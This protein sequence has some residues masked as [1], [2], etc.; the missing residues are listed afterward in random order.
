M[1]L[2]KKQFTTEFAG[3]TLTMEVSKL[4]EQATS[5]V[6]GRYGDA[7]V[8]VTVVMSEQAK[9]GDYFPLMVNYEERFY[10]AGKILGS[11]FMRREGRPSENAVLAGR[12]IDRTIR[13]LFDQ[14]TRN[15]VQVVVTILQID[16]ETDLD[17]LT[18]ATTSVALGIS[19]IPWNGPVAGV[20]L[21]HDGSKVA[22]NPALSETA[23]AWPV[24]GGF[25]AFVAGT[26]DRMNMIELEGV[27]ALDTEVTK[28]FD[29][30]QKDIAKLVDWQKGI[31]KEIGVEKVAMHLAEAD[32]ATTAK[33][34]A[35]LKEHK[36]DEVAYTRDKQERQNRLAE[37]KTALIEHLTAE[38]VD[39][40]SLVHLD[41]IIDEEIDRIMHRRILE[42]DERP[43]GR[44][45]DEVR[46]LYGETGLFSRTH[47][48]ALFVRG[49]TQALAITTLAPP[50]AERLMETMSNT[51]KRSFMLHYNFPPYSVGEAGRM[52]TPG[53][54]EI[55]HG[56]LAHKAVRNVLPSKEEFPYVIRVV[57]EIL[58][59]NGSSSMAT[60]CGTIMSLMDAGVPI[61][62]PVAGIAM[63]MVV[64]AKGTYK[65]L[66][67]IQGPEDHYGDMDLKVAG[68]TDGIRAMQMDVKIGGLT[69]KMIVDGLAQAKKARLEIL[70]VMKG[71]IAEPRKEL[72]SYAPVI[73]TINIHPS[74]IGEIIGPGGKVINAI[75]EETGVLTIDI[76]QDGSVF[77]AGPDK[78]SAEAAYKTVE[79]IVREYKAGDVVEGKVVKIMDFGA[80]VAFGHGRDGMV[81]VSELKDGFVQ[82]V[83]DVVKM[84][85]SVRAKVIKT[86]PG[87]RIGLS[88]KNV[89][90]KE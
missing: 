89:P 15:E 18:L 5:A 47:G 69:N 46:P 3:R 55:G 6:L 20:K 56:S 22:T 44:K 63:G 12:I 85:D 35:F 62:K 49:G 48:S 10:A 66:T 60:V 53:R 73:L 64:D 71:V 25:I 21:F 34:K 76:E 29:A 32:K 16:E 78:A 11:R 51:E 80:I 33:A 88:L 70:E 72:S 39:E 41:L 87:G 65:I 14:R 67:D 28:A 59:S 58:S 90:P 68:T 26:A 38:D 40:K 17:F 23:K 4:A 9:G 13:P 42:K 7:V 8:L 31:I 74:K 27:D 57:S 79:G 75:I 50:G 54:R 61:K 52:G 24:D 30:A 83:E 82:K 81:H 19:K 45:L 84:G 86:E 2:D 77:I 43:D 1:T 37:L 36:L